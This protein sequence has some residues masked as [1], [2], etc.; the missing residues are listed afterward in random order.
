MRY[1]DHYDWTVNISIGSPFGI[2]VRVWIGDVN[3]TWKFKQPLKIERV[4]TE[5]VQAAVMGK[6]DREIA[7]VLKVMEKQEPLR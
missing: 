6:I 2:F 4:D 1:S 7:E 3:W 5:Q